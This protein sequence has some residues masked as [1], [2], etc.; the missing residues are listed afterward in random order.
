VEVD[1]D[2][3]VEPPGEVAKIAVDVGQFLARRVTDLVAGEQIE[4]PALQLGHGAF[5]L[6]EAGGGDV[7]GVLADL[8]L[9]QT[10]FWCAFVGLLDECSAHRLSSGRVSPRLRGLPAPPLGA[11]AWSSGSST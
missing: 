11:V 6:M 7:V 4:A 9:G 10:V 1:G 8:P 5:E 3:G 2:G